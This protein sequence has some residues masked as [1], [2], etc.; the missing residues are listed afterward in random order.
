MLG[1]LPLV[2]NINQNVL[3]FFSIFNINHLTTAQHLANY[4]HFLDQ[5]ETAYRKYFDWRLKPP[6]LAL[7]R[8]EKPW[9]NLCQKLMMENQVNYIVKNEKPPVVAKTQKTYQYIYSW[10]FVD[11]VNCQSQIKP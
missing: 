5:N 4:L 7:L 10:W 9:C 2:N 11:G 6:G 8:R 1:I 3:I